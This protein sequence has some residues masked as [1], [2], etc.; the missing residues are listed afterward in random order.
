ME[1]MCGF[2]YR[3]VVI[4]EA[5]H[6]QD[7]WEASNNNFAKADNQ[8]DCLL[9]SETKDSEILIRQSRDSLTFPQPGGKLA[10]P[11][12]PGVDVHLIAIIIVIRICSR[13]L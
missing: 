11:C 6:L 10:L 8:F 5:S 3:R 1:N 7:Q 13:M 4:P 9:D 2:S 12:V